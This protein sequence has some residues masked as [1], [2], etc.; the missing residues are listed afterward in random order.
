MP[1]SCTV[2]DSARAQPELRALVV[3]EHRAAALPWRLL[4][5]G[6][7]HCYC[8]IGDRLDWM[9]CDPLTNRIGLMSVQGLSEAELI[10]VLA[11][12][13]G[14]VLRGGLCSTLSS[15]P[16]R[17]RPVSCVE[18]VKRVLGL[19]LPRVLTPFQLYRALLTPAGSRRPFAVATIPD[20]DL[21]N[22]SK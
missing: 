10:R 2:G 8:M 15:H 14:T 17:I 22:E 13:G 1:N 18:I 6:F 5:P 21:D 7:R 19:D 9:L 16:L 20:L 3:F 12:Q 11:G 4:R